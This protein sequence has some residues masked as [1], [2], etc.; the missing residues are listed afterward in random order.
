MCEIYSQAEEVLIFLGDDLEPS[1]SSATSR[2]RGRLGK[3][4]PSIALHGDSTD[5]SLLSSVLSKW[6]SAAQEPIRALDVFCLLR[7]LSEPLG[8]SSRHEALSKVPK[9]HFSVLFEALRR[10]LTVRWWSRIWVVQEVI[11]AKNLTVMYGNV[12]LPWTILVTASSCSRQGTTDF[13]DLILRDDLKVLGLLSWVTDLNDSRLRWNE[14]GGD[15]LLSLL[16]HFGSR[17]ASDNRDKIYALLG[18][19]R[20]DNLVQ[21]D[22]SLDDRGAYIATTFNLLKTEGSFSALTG[23]LARKDKQDLPSW[24][25]DWSRTMGEHEC[26]RVSWYH[27][28]NACGNASR[29]RAAEG[30]QIDDSVVETMLRKKNAHVISRVEEEM[31]GLVQL[32]G[33]VQSRENFLPQRMSSVLRLYRRA[34]PDLHDICDRLMEYCHQ[35]GQLTMYKSTI[36]LD[37]VSGGKVLNGGLSM[38]G[39]FITNVEEVKEPLYWDSDMDEARKT[40]RGWF[41]GWMTTGGGLSRSG[42]AL[43]YRVSRKP[44]INDPVNVELY[45]WKMEPE[46]PEEGMLILG[47]EL[48][49]TS[50]P[51]QDPDVLRGRNLRL[52]NNHL[53]SGATGANRAVE[54]LN[55]EFEDWKT[56]VEH[57]SKGSLVAF[58]S[59]LTSGMKMEASEPVPL[60]DADED[61]LIYWLLLIVLRQRRLFSS[62]ISD[63]PPDSVIDSFTRAMQISTSRRAMFLTSDGSLGLGPASMAHGDHIYILPGG[64]LPFLIRPAS[65][66]SNS[67]IGDCYLHGAMKGEKGLLAPCGEVIGHI[68]EMAIQY[69]DRELKSW[70][71]KLL[72]HSYSRG[73]IRSWSESRW[74]HFKGL[75]LQHGAQGD[76]DR[77]RAL[78]TDYE[79]LLRC[80]ELSVYPPRQTIYLI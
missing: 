45:H 65:D 29:L 22:Y 75:L 43:L 79:D 73:S 76:Y 67:M 34:N 63:P 71:G 61:N 69:T 18:L 58:A 4:R 59:T 20:S 37:P 53:H 39:R 68:F 14:N 6:S 62:L 47:S 32:L 25:P 60:T 66:G 56:G 31:A 35:D 51:S 3:G 48:I 74:E 33:S 7:I 57:R 1:R 42:L 72:L 52:L 21:P 27:K 23:N 44:H 50:P 19:C 12:S 30:V 78:L 46:G 70:A 8:L 80:K 17:Q 15:G 38:S 64:R 5:E 55:E 11:V 10:M 36:T 77:I 41:R 16:R 2:N 9:G 26:H 28:Y 49:K 54:P 13:S 24:V 40:I